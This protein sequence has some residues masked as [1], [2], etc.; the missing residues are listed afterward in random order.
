MGIGLRPGAAALGAG[1][2]DRSVEGVD[3]LGVEA[4]R[5]FSRLGGVRRRQSRI[6]AGD[7]KIGYATRGR[8]AAMVGA[9]ESQSRTPRLVLLCDCE[10][11]KGLGWS[12]GVLE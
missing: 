2:Y 10:V 6:R 4:R 8:F 11:G 12:S 9:S 5:Y 3:R 1:L 7:G